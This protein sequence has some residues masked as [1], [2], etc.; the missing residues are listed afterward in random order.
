MGR[1]RRGSPDAF[2]YAAGRLERERRQREMGDPLPELAPG[3][4]VPGGYR[5]Q[6]RA[7]WIIVIVL[8][9]LVLGRGAAQRSL[10][11]DCSRAKLRLTPATTEPMQRVRWSATGP[12]GTAIEVRLDARPVTA[13]GAVLTKCQAQGGFPAPTGLGGHRVTLVDVADG[14]TI[15]TA[16]LVVTG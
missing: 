11:A 15:A 9:L 13:T 10:S 1:R 8:L 7:T 16:D 14:R 6:R 5:R 2:E 12:K 3:L 4:D